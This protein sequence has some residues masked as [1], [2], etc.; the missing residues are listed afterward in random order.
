[1]SPIVAARTAAVAIAFLPMIGGIMTTSY[2]SD[3]LGMFVPIQQSSLDTMM[4]HF[5]AY[6]RAHSYR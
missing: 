1:M 4:H 6:S 3:Y 5:Y 2:E